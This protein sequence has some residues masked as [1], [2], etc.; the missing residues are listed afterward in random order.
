M[1]EA[2][3]K[4]VDHWHPVIQRAMKEG[5]VELAAGV[6]RPSLRHFGRNV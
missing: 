1:V 3:P 5:V 6:D 4:A 2:I